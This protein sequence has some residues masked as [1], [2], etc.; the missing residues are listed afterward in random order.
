MAPKPPTFPNTWEG[1]TAAAKQAGAKFTELVAGLWALESGWGK[2]TPAGESFNFFG[3]KEDNDTASETKEFVGGKWI[4]IKAE[5]LAFPD[6]FT[7][8]D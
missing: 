8:V 3:L 4:T 7:C 1:V 2:H 5:F 6:L